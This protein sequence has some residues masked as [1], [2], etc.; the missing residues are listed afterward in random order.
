VRGEIVKK[1][2][3]EG[4]DE[5][6]SKAYMDVLVVENIL[7][8]LIVDTISIVNTFTSCDLFH[9]GFEIGDEVILNRIDESIIDDFSGHPYISPG[10]CSSILLTL[11]DGI[12]NGNIREELNTQ[13]FDEFKSSIGACSDLTALDRWITQIDERLFIFPNPCTD[14]FFVNTSIIVN[15]KGTYALYDALGQ[16]IQK[17]EQYLNNQSFRIE[18]KNYP[19]GVYFLKIQV[20]DQMVTKKILKE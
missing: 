7:G 3:V 16:L 14:Y 18:V 4:V 1:Y 9:D 13:S 12:V 19:R 17:G 6:N 11:K 5:F 2:E 15:E 8:N 20:R 10:S